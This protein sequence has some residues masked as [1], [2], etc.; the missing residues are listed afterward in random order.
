MYVQVDKEMSSIGS[1]TSLNLAVVSPTTIQV[2]NCRFR[3][4]K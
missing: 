1:V 3:A 4:V 2:T